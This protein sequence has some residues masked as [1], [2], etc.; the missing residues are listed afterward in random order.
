MNAEARFLRALQRA[1]RASYRPLRKLDHTI[2]R[3]IFEADPS[4][5][6]LLTEREQQMMEEATRLV[7]ELTQSM[8]QRKDR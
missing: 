5:D 3:A 6:L 7:N 8:M 1:V 4:L 2:G